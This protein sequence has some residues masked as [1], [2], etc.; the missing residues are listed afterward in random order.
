MTRPFALMAL[1]VLAACKS[2][3]APLVAAPQEQARFL[4]YT[5]NV[6]PGWKVETTETADQWIVDLVPSSGDVVCSLGVIKDTEFAAEEYRK[7][8]LRQ[9]KAR[10]PSATSLE[11]GVGKFEG[12]RFEAT[13]GET[14]GTAEVLCLHRANGWLTLVLFQGGSSSLRDACARQFATGQD[15]VDRVANVIPK[16][17]GDRPKTDVV[18]KKLTISKS[19]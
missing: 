6:A 8:M 17:P 10:S 14:R 15:V 9:F 12:S 3:E 2:K 19:P 18:I 11:T 5:M 13:L 16:N 4:G 7:Q 1:A